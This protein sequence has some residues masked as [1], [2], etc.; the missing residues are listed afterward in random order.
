MENRQTDTERINK[1][2]ISHRFARVV[3]TY[4]REAVAQKRIAERMGGLLARHLPHPCSKV[5]EIGCGTG[6]LTRELSEILHPDRL[7]LNDLCREMGAC[8]TDLT[9]GGQTVFLPGDA[10]RLSFPPEQNLIVSCSALQWFVSPERFFARC[11]PLLCREG[12]FAF[13]T[14]GRDNLKEVISVTGTG[15]RYRTLSELEEALQT[16]YKIVVATEERIILS[17]NTPLEILYH[18]KN[19]GV[20]ALRQQAWTKSDLRAF[21]EAY[22]RTPGQV[23]TVELT[24]HPIYFIA[25]KLN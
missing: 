10:E 6:F 7:V 15:L 14:F 8:F 3:D 12:Y 9:S 24:Y 4:N 21:C 19:T 23:E 25:K 20:T 5:L 1:S 13:T 18:L 17:F 2:L 22:P 16:H 11:H